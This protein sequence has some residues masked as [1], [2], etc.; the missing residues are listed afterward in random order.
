MVTQKDVFL[1]EK[2]IYKDCAYEKLLSDTEPIKI[3]CA[4]SWPVCDDYSDQDMNYKN[5]KLILHDPPGIQVSVFCRKILQ[6][7]DCVLMVGL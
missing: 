4:L 1:P 2:G 7:T 6:N 5:M 3:M